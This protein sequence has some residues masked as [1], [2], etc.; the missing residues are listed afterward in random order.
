LCTVDRDDRRAVPLV[1][2]VAEP[3]LLDPDLRE[4]LHVVDVDARPRDQLDAVPDPAGVAVGSKRGLRAGPVHRVDHVPLDLLDR[5]RLVRPV[6]RRERVVPE[7]DLDVLG[8]VPRR[9]VLDDDDVGR[10][11]VH[12]VGHVELE[13]VEHP[14]M[15]AEIR[16]VQPDV[17]EI[18]DRAEPEEQPLPAKLVGNPELPPE[19]DRA[20]EVADLGEV[21]V[22]RELHL[23][24]GRSVEVR[25]RVTA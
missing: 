3:V 24:P 4:H 21:P 19:P 8:R 13:R 16:A 14:L 12:D 2:A 6:R 22:G 15:R 9:R 20:E 17:G 5:L 7:V 25:I 18:V 11:G 23:A 10:V 1:E